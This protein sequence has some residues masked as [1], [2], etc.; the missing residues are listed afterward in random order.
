[1]LDGVLRHR[2][3]TRLLDRVGE[4]EVRGRIPTPLA[5]SDDQRARELGEQLPALRVG[6]ALLVLDRAPLAMPGHS[7]PLA[8]GRGT[9]RAR[10]CRRSTRGG[11][12][13]GGRG[14]PA[15]A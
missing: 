4:G 6:G 10:G 3:R 7:P 12:T 14:R 8:R 9:A 2:V 13:R 1:P 15:G 11:T 5:R